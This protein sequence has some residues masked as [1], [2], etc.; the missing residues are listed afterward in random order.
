MN[1]QHIGSDFDKFLA[2]EG[3]L[4]ETEAVA[5]KRIIAGGSTP[6]F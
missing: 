5:V 1:Q 4:A 3:L 2:E 6:V